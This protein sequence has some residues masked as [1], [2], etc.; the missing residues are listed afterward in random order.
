MQVQRLSIPQPKE[1]RG[2]W[3]AGR[4]RD[5]VQMPGLR[6][7]V[8]R[9]NTDQWWMMVTKRRVV[10]AGVLAA[11]IVL[12]I[13][14]RVAPL[15]WYPYDKSLGDVLYA[16]AAYLALAFLFPRMSKGYFAALATAG[17]LAVEFLQLTEI[18][19]DL[20]TLP[21]LR[22]FLGTTF[23]WHDVGCYLLGITVAVACDA[24]IHKE[25]AD[26]PPPQS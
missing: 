23:S 17:C 19:K 26:D 4:V 5:E 2:S 15:G 21:V 13:I 25:I 16:M 24:F 9:E 12:G 18:N 11:V 10:A 8:E 6:A 7:C 1:D 22:W 14:S 20:L 3:K